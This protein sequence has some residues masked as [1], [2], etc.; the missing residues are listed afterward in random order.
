MGGSGKEER[1]REGKRIGL[2]I[3]RK[4]HTELV[5]GEEDGERKE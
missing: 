4:R 2:A 5:M 3:N 1:K